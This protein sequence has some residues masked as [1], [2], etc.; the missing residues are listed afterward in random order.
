MM[1]RMPLAQGNGA[2]IHPIYISWPCMRNESDACPRAVPNRMIRDSPRRQCD[3]DEFFMLARPR[4]C[5]N[6]ESHIPNHTTKLGLN[7]TRR[8][9][10]TNAL[11]FDTHYGVD[12]FREIEPHRTGR[13]DPGSEAGTKPSGAYRRQDRKVHPSES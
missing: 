9:D 7:Q 11:C 4:Q 12:E 13:G 6:F 5:T 1:A 10:I 2:E 3:R 8:T